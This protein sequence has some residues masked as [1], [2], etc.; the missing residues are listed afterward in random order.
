MWYTV[1]A[2]EFMALLWLSPAVFSFSLPYE[3][4]KKTKVIVTG[5]AGKTGK[6]VFSKL[7]QNPLFQPIGV[8]RS[9]KS[10]K[11]LLKEVMCDLDHIFIADVTTL[12]KQAAIPEV[13]QGSKAMVSYFQGNSEK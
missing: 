9:E 2:A 11:A 8:V 7:K 3:T 5:A 6:L 4:P 1:V 13:L 12:D 10:A